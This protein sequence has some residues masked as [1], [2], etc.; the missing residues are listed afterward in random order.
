MRGDW[1]LTE[2]SALAF[3]TAQADTHDQKDGMGSSGAG[4][5]NSRKDDIH[6]RNCLAPVHTKEGLEW[7]LIFAWFA[8]RL[9]CSV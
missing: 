6:G 9:A 1:R 8:T 2:G 3:E 5:G 7:A 4:V